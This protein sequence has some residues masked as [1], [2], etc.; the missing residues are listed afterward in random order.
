[1]NTQC[2]E[3]ELLEDTVISAT[4]ATS[5]A[6]HSLDY[7]PGAA[8]W[9]ATASR[10][11]AA[12]GQQAFE[13]FHGDRSCFADGLPIV[14]DRVAWPVP[15][16]WH[17]AKFEPARV[18][19]YLDGESIWNMAVDSRPESDQLK[20]LRDAHVDMATGRWIKPRMRLRMKT[21]LA[22]G[23]AAEGQLFG[24]EALP[25]GSRFL[26]SIGMTDADL[27]ERAVRLLEEGILIGRSRSAEYGRAGIRRVD[28]PR[29][30][31]AASPVDFTTVY[32]ASDLC[33][34]DAHAQP[35]VKPDGSMLGLGELPLDPARSFVRTR[36]YAPWNA[37][38]RGHDMERQVLTRGSVLVFGGRPDADAI[39][40]LASNG[41]GLYRSQGLGRVLV[42]P[43]FAA[44]AVGAFEDAGSADREDPARSEPPPDTP[45]VRLLRARA[46]T[47]EVEIRL[48]RHAEQIKQDMVGR[49]RQARLASGVL[50]SQ[51]FGPSKSQWSKLENLPGVHSRDELY[52]EIFGD[53]QQQ[54]R[55]RQI[56]LARADHENWSTPIWI[57]SEQK[58]ISDWFREVLDA[59]WRCEPVDGNPDK[60]RRLVQHI[61]RLMAKEAGQ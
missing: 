4:S 56:G 35:C 9:G 49:L 28:P 8:L 10:L 11:Y 41:A 18:D 44:G 27:L 36:R 15:L 59:R 58:S 52:S 55:S 17:E 26:A 43:W 54:D 51:L 3:I 1:M 20:Q 39:E 57:G 50:D 53:P 33:L 2:I 25:A 46:G 7:I 12:L 47:R 19:G 5:G 21:A 34:L 31:S 16:S 13:F 37:Y 60:L 42:D 61:A 30:V 14:D 22:N 48:V 32:L 29:Q 45:L 23:T 24:Y 38:R 40:R 6:H